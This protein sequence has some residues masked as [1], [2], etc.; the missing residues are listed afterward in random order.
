MV[1]IAGV[2]LWDSLTANYPI[3]V[4]A[5]AEYGDDIG[6]HIFTGRGNLYMRKVG[7]LIG[8][9]K[10]ARGN[11]FE[12]GWSF[13]NS[14]TGFCEGQFLYTR[15]S[16]HSFAV[17]VNPDPAKAAVGTLPDVDAIMRDRSV[18]TVVKQL[19][20]LEYDRLINQGDATISVE[21]GQARMT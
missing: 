21:S 17:F 8:I 7:L 6:Q 19:R 11:F 15:F 13:F 1:F 20:D 5:W 16:G 4:L 3:E 2:E 14:L 12:T 9:D 10:D 18:A